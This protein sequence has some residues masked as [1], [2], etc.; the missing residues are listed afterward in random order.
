MLL[1][2]NEI[3]K[4]VVSVS[5]AKHAVPQAWHH[6][7]ILTYFVSKHEYVAHRARGSSIASICH[8]DC[9]FASSLGAQ[10]PNVTKKNARSLN[11]AIA[12][13]TKSP[14]Q[15]LYLCRWTLTQC[16]FIKLATPILRLAMTTHCNC[17]FYYVLWK[18]TIR[19][20]FCIMPLSS[21]NEWP[22]VYWSHGSMGLFL[23]SNVCLLSVPRIRRWKVNHR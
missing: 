21:A 3:D 18:I 8:Q 6:A 4:T 9:A 23:V 1:I 17:A 11:R 2:F 13:R 7:L 20:P 15:N 19:Q 16:K 10:Y 14:V 5:L 22:V 12:S